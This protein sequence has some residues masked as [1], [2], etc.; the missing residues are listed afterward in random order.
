MKGD[1][2]LL[3]GDLASAYSEYQRLLSE[4]EPIER[5]WGYQRLA[6]LSVLQGRFKQAREQLTSGLKEADTHDEKGWS[7]LFHLDLARL[8]LER[9]DSR[10]AL[11][12]CDKAWKIA[13]LGETRDF[14]RKVL[15]LRGLAYLAQRRINDAEETADLLKSLCEKGP[16]LDRMRSYFL[17]KGRIEMSRNNFVAA[18][19][20]ITQAVKLLPLQG[21]PAWEYNDHA[22]Y[23]DALAEAFYARGDP[24]RAYEE[25]NKL[26]ALLTGR[27]GYGDLYAR[28][29]YKQAKISEEKL[30]P[31][32]AARLYEKFLAFW[33]EGDLG[34]SEVSDARL[35]LRAILGQAP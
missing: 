13:M 19:E 17:L 22:L 14:P 33:G 24:G 3:S 32:T 9:K 1:V 35:R 5:L 23:Y 21:P 18:I 29:F 2:L 4:D 16:G 27:L 31:E 26:R 8:A 12:E 11:A 6:H 15:F 30:F 28:T 20:Y 10:L 7:Y 25:L 34:S